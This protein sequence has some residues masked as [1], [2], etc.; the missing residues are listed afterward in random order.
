MPTPEFWGLTFGEFWPLY[1]AVTSTGKP[2]KKH[3]TRQDLKDM[4]RA[5][6]DGNFRR[7]GGGLSS[8]HEGATE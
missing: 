4:E 2:K 1:D 8:K 5:F 3:V 7:T 6:A